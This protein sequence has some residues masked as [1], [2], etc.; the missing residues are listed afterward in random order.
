MSTKSGLITLNDDEKITCSACGSLCEHGKLA[1][2]EEIEVV[3]DD[4]QQV[5]FFCEE[6]VRKDRNV[7]EDL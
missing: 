4:Q 3:V 5:T 6:C 7:P 1:Q 2:N